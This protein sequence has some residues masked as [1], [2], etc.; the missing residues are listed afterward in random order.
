MNKY[1]N[2]L[3][4][5]ELIEISISEQQNTSEVGASQEMKTLK[6]ESVPCSSRNLDQD[7]QDTLPGMVH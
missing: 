4:H 6:K 3:D 5:R 1:V 7:H 2:R